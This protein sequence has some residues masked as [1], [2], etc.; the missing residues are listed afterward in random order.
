MKPRIL[1]LKGLPASGKS[2]FA[3]NTE[4]CDPDNVYIICKDDIR[5]HH[6]FKREKQVI[7]KRDELIEFALD[8]DFKLI[9]IADT[10]LNPIHL[11]TI[12]Q[13]FSDRA[14][15][16]VND[17]FLEVPL[18]ECIKRDLQRPNPVGKDVILRMYYEW[19]APKVNT[20]FNTNPRVGDNYAY[21]CD[22]DGTFAVLNGRNPFDES[23]VAND[24]INV[25]LLHI[26]NGI[27]AQQLHLIFVSGRHDT[28]EKQTREFL[29]KAGF[30]AFKL[31]MRKAGDDRSDAIV[32]KEIYDKHI[33]PHYKVIGAFDD[34]P[35]V[36]RVWR[37]L[38]IQVF[39]MGDGYEF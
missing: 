7:A 19:I 35:K 27:I 29:S 2:T 31:L 21:L 13:K 36:C 1:L 14:D 8:N 4:R 15:I 37:D 10:N 33:I 20:Q 28:C 30:G 24:L 6:N 3:A 32:K 9:I 39:N 22:L 25:P 16:E 26:L 18:I 11:K 34:R 12:T 17:S 5:A 23:S 38:G